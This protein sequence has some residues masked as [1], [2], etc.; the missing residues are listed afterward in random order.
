MY[1]AMKSPQFAYGLRYEGLRM[2]RRVLNDPESV[3][4]MKKTR[5]GLDFEPREDLPKELVGETDLGRVE[6]AKAPLLRKLL[7]ASL[8]PLLGAKGEKKPGGEIVYEGAIGR[9]PLKGTISISNLHAHESCENSHE[10]AKQLNRARQWDAQRML[11][12][13]EAVPRMIREWRW[14][15]R[16]RQAIAS[17]R[18]RHTTLFPAW[19][20]RAGG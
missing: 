5:A 6:T 16:R 13:R 9:V 15:E 19:R 20:R 11:G 8:T 7:K 1:A 18:R 10:L 4:Q 3:A 14:P 12:Y 17:W 2:S